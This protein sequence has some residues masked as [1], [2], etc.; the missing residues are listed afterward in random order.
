MVKAKTLDLH[1]CCGF[2]YQYDVLMHD[3]SM[4]TLFAEEYSVGKFCRRNLP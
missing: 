2:H 4:V 1:R 3:I